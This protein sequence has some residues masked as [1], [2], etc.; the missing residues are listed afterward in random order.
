MSKFATTASDSDNLTKLA[1]SLTSSIEKVA[2]AEIE[3][4]CVKMSTFV[5][6]MGHYTTAVSTHSVSGVRQ[7]NM[8]DNI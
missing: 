7:I 1:G 3:S 5:K 6:V 4:R 8:A 2:V